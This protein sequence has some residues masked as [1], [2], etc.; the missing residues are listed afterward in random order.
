[1]GGHSLKATIVA[2]KIFKELHVEIPI[3]KLFQTPNIKSLADDIQT[4]QKSKYDPIK[5]LN[6]QQFYA[7][8]PAQNRLLAIAKLDESSV[9][10]NISGAFVIKGSLDK[11]RFEQAFHSL[12]QRHESLRTSF[13]YIDF[14]AKQIINEKINYK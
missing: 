3:K 1:L 7:T 4:V 8:S 5:P 11:S 12:V 13:Q 14:E 9:N 2:A 10:Y 6:K